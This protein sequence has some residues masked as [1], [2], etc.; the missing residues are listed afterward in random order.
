M[1]DQGLV[2]GQTSLSNRMRRLIERIEKL[3]KQVKEL[4]KNR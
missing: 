2:D 1:S 4:E 3:E